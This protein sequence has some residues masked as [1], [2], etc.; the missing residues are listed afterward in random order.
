MKR[1]ITNPDLLQIALN[2]LKPETRGLFFSCLS[3][4]LSDFVYKTYKNTLPALLL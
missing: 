2:N 1:E 4:T 3:A